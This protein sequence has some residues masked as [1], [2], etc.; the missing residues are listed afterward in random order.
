MCDVSNTAFVWIAPWESCLAQAAHPGPRFRAPG[1][2][3]AAWVRPPS[4]QARTA[5]QFLTAAWIE[6]LKE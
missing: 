3:M 1:A 6:N 5:D 4:K 2:R